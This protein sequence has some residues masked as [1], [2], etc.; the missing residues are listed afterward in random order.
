MA[1]DAPL[2]TQGDALDFGFTLSDTAIQRASARIRGHLSQHLTSGASTIQARG[3]VFRLPQRPVVT[4]STVV[5]ADG[6]A[7]E[8]DLSGSLLTVNSLG[9]VTVTY[10]HGY[11]TL[12]DALVELVCQVASRLDTP[13]P[14]LAAG[15][16]T[17][18]AG[19]LSVGYGWDSYKAQAGLTQGEKDALRQYWPPLPNVITMGSPA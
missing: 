14:E 9:L 10:T 3:P 5:D 1:V 8:W 6:K 16:Q 12:P 4:V 18:G 17:L 2:I 13:T 7:V 15:V 11:A 19:P